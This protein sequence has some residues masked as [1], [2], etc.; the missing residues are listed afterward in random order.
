[1]T[2]L[3]S[4]LRTLVYQSVFQ[5]G[6]V[7]QR[8]LGEK[9]YNMVESIRKKMVEL[10]K[11]SD[12]NSFQQLNT[13]YRQIEKWSTEDRTHLAHAFTLMLELMNACENAYRSYRLDQKDHTSV[14][15]KSKLPSAVIYV[16]TAH[17]TE[18]R[19]PQNIAVF[20]LIQDLL[21]Q[22]LVRATNIKA[23][24]S[25]TAS[26]SE[27]L[28][29]L[30]ELAWH[31]PIARKRSPHVKDEA[32]HIY[33]LILRD[34]VL[35]ALLD[36]ESHDVP[37]FIR[38]WV[39]GDKDGHPGVNEKV[40]RESLSLSR[41]RLVEVATDLLRQV[42]QSLDYTQSSK[43]LT[44]LQT[45]LQKVKKAL[46][47]IKV[48]K[49][50]D[51]KRIDSMH[52]LVHSFLGLY[53]RSFG[54]EHPS[55][56][57]LKKLLHIF[58]AL[59]IPLELRESSDVLMSRPLSQPSLV[60]DRMLRLLADLSDGGDPRWY[61]RGFIISMTQKPEHVIM[62]FKRQRLFLK[63]R[64]IPVIPLFEDAESLR[65]AE[66]IMQV[67][68]KMP[69]IKSAAKNDWGARFEMMVG[70][71]DSSKESGALYSR[72]AIAT[73]L[74]QLE[75]VCKK[76]GLT[77]VFFHG[78]GG[79]VDRGGG[80]IDDQIAWWP[81]TALDRY[82]VTIQGEMIDRSLATPSIAQRQV[83]KIIE[84]AAKGLTQKSQPLPSSELKKFS[85]RVASYY[86]Q[87]ITESEFLKISERA[88]PYS[89]LNLLKI[90]SRPSKRSGELTVKN[91]RAIPWVL[92]WTQT[93]VL[94]QTWWGVGSAWEESTSAQKKALK[95]S[96]KKEAVFR[97]Y[98]KALG[99]TIAK[100]EMPVWKVYLS[101]CGLPQSEVDMVYASFQKE[102]QRT[103][104]AYQ[105][106]T[107]EKQFLWFR[108]WLG[109]SIQLR[110]SMIH[111]LNLLQITAKKKNE[112]DL[113][114]VTVTGIS[115]G[116]LTTG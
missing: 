40:M 59:V 37:L 14:A 69:Q 88:T 17:P 92:C 63:K 15:P 54:V 84:Y 97:S 46:S 30:L 2:H 68:L 3:S 101:Q 70:Y 72:I 29:H 109:E 111:P 32:E 1:M 77:S 94:F 35:L 48:L 27:K 115:S 47:Q 24:F 28:F 110:S 58:P 56:L 62:A 82:K 52:K 65:D 86:R 38:T 20:H 108:P 6:L 7:I 79:S 34:H 106:I 114:R 49:K 53:T 80:S 51:A 12:E 64:S 75:R 102:Y 98:I 4:E 113:L 22:S 74:P 18:A 44:D 8:E 96:Y 19:S 95:A 76:A 71:S 87:T 103:I 41:K 55:L 21:Q 25:L 16:L 45:D 42:Q 13:L 10:R 39:G 33:S 90:G 50:S 112:A 100:V 66:Q 57:Q 11:A 31:T 116:M 105:E 83:Q 99:F 43:L 89:Y 5:F 81:K 85:G 107:G 93:R 73:A 91:L 78:S 67:L 104:R 9:K 26:E 61:V 36:M 23:E 60:I